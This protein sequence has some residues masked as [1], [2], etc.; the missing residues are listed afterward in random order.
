MEQ[1]TNQ[2]QI[3][4]TGI[5]YYYDGNN[6]KKWIKTVC[7]FANNVATVLIRD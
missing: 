1:N 3:L 2:G 7:D 4:I 5:L 6:D